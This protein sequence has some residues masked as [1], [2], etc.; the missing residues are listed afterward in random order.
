M[1]DKDMMWRLD[2]QNLF[3]MTGHEKILASQLI[4][5][6]SQRRKGDQRGEVIEMSNLGMFCFEEGRDE[7]AIM[8]LSDSCA[9]AEKLEIKDWLVRT[10]VNLGVAHRYGGSQ[11]QALKCYMR[12]WQLAVDVPVPECIYTSGSNIMILVDEEDLR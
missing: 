6:P 5:I 3:E 1:S 4:L 8:Y 11:I 10:L 9:M 12:A 7:E 2:P